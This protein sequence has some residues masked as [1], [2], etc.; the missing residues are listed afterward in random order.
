MEWGFKM[1]KLGKSLGARVHV[2]EHI[3]ENGDITET[4]KILCEETE[5]LGFGMRCSVLYY[6]G[7]KKTLHHA[8]APSLPDFYTQAIDGMEAGEGI[9]SCGTAAFMGKRVIVEDVYAHPY[10]VQFR[11]LAKKTGFSACWSQPIFSKDKDVLGTFAMYYDEVHSPSDDELLLIEAQANL[12]SLAIERK[13]ASELILQAKDEAESANR[14]KAEFLA[15][16]SHELRTPLNA[17]LGFAQVLELSPSQPLTE[18]QKIA[19]GHIRNGGVHLLTLIDDVLD[20]ARIEN[21]GLGLEFEAVKTKVLIQDSVE[22]AQTLIC[23]RNIS[24]KVECSCSGMLWADY[25][26]LK[27]ILLNLISNAVK[28]NHDGGAVTISCQTASENR[29]RISVSDTGLGIA[30]DKQDKLF[31]P[32]S[33]LGQERSAIQGTGIGLVVAKQFS[34]GMNGIIGFE[35]V[36]GEG[37]TFWIEIPLIKVNA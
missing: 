19:V 20:F 2:L 11:E 36:E 23:E 13:Q 32:F 28:Y 35:S 10:W 21:R 16:M 25:T 8:A 14:A 31:L 30:K 9:G 33:R 22:M 3:V 29:Q 5:A 18:H 27:Q 37:S 4:L 26:R 34:E 1:D 24:I 7:E 6:D 17:I 15:S 12:A